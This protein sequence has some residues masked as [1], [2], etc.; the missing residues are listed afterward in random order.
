V[1]EGNDN[2]IFLLVDELFRAFIFKDFISFH[3]RSDASKSVTETAM[4]RVLESRK[5]ALL[6]REDSK[7]ED[8]DR[9]KT[10]RYTSGHTHWNSNSGNTATQSK[11]MRA[12]ERER[13]PSPVGQ[14]G[15]SESKF[16]ANANASDR[17]V[18]SKTNPN[19]RASIQGTFGAS[20]K[21]PAHPEKEK[22]AVLTAKKVCEYD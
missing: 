14:R 7:Y 13:S 9:A 8:D 12:H 4:T 18:L 1:V 6:K 16:D 17:I 3:I 15:D 22:E 5:Q 19:R 21:P 2:R 10:N 11:K 20:A